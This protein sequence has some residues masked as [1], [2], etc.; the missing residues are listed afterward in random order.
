MTRLKENADPFMV[1]LHEGSRKEP[2]EVQGKRWRETVRELSCGALDGVVDMAV[3]RRAYLGIHHWTPYRCRIV[4]V[5]DETTHEY[6]TCLTNIPGEVLTP[7][8]VA[9]LYGARWEI[10]L[11]FKELKSR[12]KL[13]QI[14]SGK[15]E[16]VE[17]LIWVAVL[18]LI[19]SRRLLHI[20]KE[21]QPR[22]LRSR[23]N[24]QRWAKVFVERGW[25]VLGM[26]LKMA[27]VAR[28]EEEVY[29]LVVQVW[30]SD[31]VDSHVQRQ[32]LRDGLWA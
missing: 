22:E 6:H 11:L 32:K 3:P 20:A 23:F 5:Y 8:E 14:R 19:V 21:S 9:T 4:A 16:V 25:Q 28:T 27:G 15:V 24:P 17:T 30:S 12:Y 2:V 31:A 13:D 29:G 26:V 7:E 1:E 10:E 18:T